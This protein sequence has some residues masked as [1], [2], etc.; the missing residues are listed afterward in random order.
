[1]DGNYDD[2]NNHASKNIH[3]L[4][5]TKVVHGKRFAGKQLEDGHTASGNNIQKDST[6]QSEPRL[7]G[8]SMQVNIETLT[9]RAK[10]LDVEGSYTIPEVKALIQD[11]QGLPSDQQRLVFRGIQLEDCRTLGDYKIQNDDTLD[12][13][14][15]LNTCPQQVS[16]SNL[17]TNLRGGNDSI[18]IFVETLNGKSFTLFVEPNDTIEKVKARIQDQEYIPPRQQNLVFKA[19]QLDDSCTISQYNIEKEDTI[20][21][22]LKLRTC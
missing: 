12:L 7:L 6:L 11:Q 21:L 5:K 9:G 17:M 14:L 15:K 20:N 16:G 22:V 2:S 8:G 10:S 13:F 4:S 1:M 18:Q 3:S 19:Q